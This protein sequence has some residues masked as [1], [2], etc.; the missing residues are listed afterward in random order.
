MRTDVC[1]LDKMTP[2]EIARSFD[3]VAAARADFPMLE[4]PMQATLLEQTRKTLLDRELATS[5]FPNVHVSHLIG[6]R[7]QWHG[8][9]G[10]NLLKKDV[11]EAGN[12]RSI[13]FV[14]VENG[15]HFVSQNTIYRRA[16]SQTLLS[17]FIM[18]LPT[19]S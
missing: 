17:S 13:R 15:N 19:L 12:P 4:R 5:F 11:E 14:E 1:S 10:R 3:A 18:M 6:L 9:L 7:T 16:N 8:I 2:E